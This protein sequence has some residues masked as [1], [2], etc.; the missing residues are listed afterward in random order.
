MASNVL[1]D[2][3]FLVALLVDRDTDHQWAVAE[4]RRLPRPWQTC[5]AA[6]SEACHLVGPAG[7]GAVSALIERRAVICNFDF[8]TQAAAVIRLMKKYDSVPM[9]FADAC[10]VRMSELLADPLVVTMDSDFQVYRRHGRQ[11]VPCASPR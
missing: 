10:L 3:S 7:V 6:L 11:V 9:S 8:A 2:S 4:A 1:A 5:E